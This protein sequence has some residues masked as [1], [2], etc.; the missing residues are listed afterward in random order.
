VRNYGI[1]DL[2]ILLFRKNAS[3]LLIPATTKEAIWFQQDGAT[4]HTAGETMELLRRH[5]P[6]RIIS[7]NGDLTW[8]LRSPDLSAPDFFLWGYLK[9]KVYINKPRTLEELKT[10]IQ[11]QIAL[12]TPETLQ[13]VMEN[14]MQRAYSCLNCNG[15]HL[16]D[17]IFHK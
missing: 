11:E 9:E 8:P 14:S 12:I 15:S 7:K 16:Q 4:A 13:K 10:N 6:N 2:W 5:F 1:K 3:E 17:I